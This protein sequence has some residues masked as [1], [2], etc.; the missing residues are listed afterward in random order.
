MIHIDD[1]NQQDIDFNEA[2]NIIKSRGKGDLLE[3]MKSIN[4]LWADYVDSTHADTSVYEDDFEFF[5]T[6][7]YEI[8]AYNAVYAGMSQL[9]ATE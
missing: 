1:Y 9:F 2:A 7:C 4:A 6:W 3:G 8:N 5:S